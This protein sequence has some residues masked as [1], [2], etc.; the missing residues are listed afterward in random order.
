[1]TARLGVGG[2]VVATAAV[3]AWALVD[4][5]ALLILPGLVVGG[6]L[7]WVTRAPGPQPDTEPELA[8]QPPPAEPE[9]EARERRKHIVRHPVPSARGDYRFLFSGV[10]CW[11]GSDPDDVSAEAAVVTAVQERARA[12]L[13]DELPEEHEALQPQLAATLDGIRCAHVRVSRLRVVE[14]RLELP[15]VDAERLDQLS[16]V[17]KRKSAREE[18]RELERLERSYLGED[19]LADPGRAVV[20]WLSRNP[21]R[22]DEAVGNI[23]TL[24]RLSSAAT[25]S[26]IPDVYRDLMREMGDSE[27]LTPEVNPDGHNAPRPWPEPGQDA[28]DG[29][30][31]AGADDAGE[32]SVPDLWHDWER[33]LHQECRDK[34]EE[35]RER[36]LDEEV[37]RI[38]DRGH[39]ELA[40]WLRR[41]FDVPD[42]QQDVPAADCAAQQQVEPPNRADY[43]GFAAAAPTPTANS[44]APLD[45]PT[46]AT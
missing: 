41:R 40:T 20:W 44:A 38:Y 29:T 26:E 13:A 5:W 28:L 22:V 45:S 9:P 34:D 30:D 11:Y 16:E 43:V 2:L 21:D 8:P 32:E 35:G 10:V 14:V 4:W 15:A 42:I 12:F 23:G 19:A 36:F 39:A 27:S 31:T 3:L 18:E 6:G 24:T 7:V 46:R 33:V 37:Q 1:M 25:G 17:R